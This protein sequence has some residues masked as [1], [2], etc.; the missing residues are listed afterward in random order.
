MESVAGFAGALLN[1]AEGEAADVLNV[2]TAFVNALLVVVVVDVI[3]WAVFDLP[4]S[5]KGEAADILSVGTAFVNALLVVVVFDVIGWAV[6][7]LPR[8]E[9]GVNPE[10]KAVFW[11]L[12][13]D[14]NGDV[15]EAGAMRCCGC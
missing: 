1:E 3:G 8:S 9:K 15:P 2:G 7:D 4:R 12:P 14:P 5:E 13:K 10:E 11:L 6:F